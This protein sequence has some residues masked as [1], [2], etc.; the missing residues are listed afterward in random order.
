[1]SELDVDTD[2]VEKGGAAL[3]DVGEKL[4][5]MREE[6]IDKISSYRGCWGTGEFG[7]AFEKKYY[8]GLDPTVAGLD[9]LAESAEASG[10]SLGGTGKKFKKVQQD[11]ID[12]LPTPKR[13]V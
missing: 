9:A 10:R 7:E 2:A 11:V 12:Q 5:I 8:Q 1:M 13:N 6:Y 3:E 4:K